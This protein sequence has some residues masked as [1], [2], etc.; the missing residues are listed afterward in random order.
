M[1]KNILT[2][3]G[4]A[5]MLMTALT[6]TACNDDDDVKIDQEMLYGYWDLK[7][8]EIGGKQYNV[9]QY[10]DEFMRVAYNDKGEYATWEWDDDTNN[11]EMDSYGT[12]KLKG[13]KLT[14]VETWDIDDDVETTTVTINT[15]NG[16]QLIISG[17]SDGKKVKFTFNRVV[18]E[19]K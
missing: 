1:K 8:A 7:T 18:F 6:F 9:S 4:M 12:Y 3:A 14:M 13:N 10:S 15:L 17:K 19:P 11:L 5:L 16:E 2:I